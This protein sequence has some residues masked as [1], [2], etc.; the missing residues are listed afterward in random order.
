[1]KKEIYVLESVD[2]RTK[3]AI[4]KNGKEKERLKEMMTN[5]ICE[6]SF[7]RIEEMAVSVLSGVV[8]DEAERKLVLEE[9]RSLPL[10]LFSNLFTQKRE[11]A[12]RIADHEKY[13]V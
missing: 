8:S 10:P 2:I 5:V 6:E 3:K 9:I 7:R 13:I 11:I 1:M 4:Q 12:E